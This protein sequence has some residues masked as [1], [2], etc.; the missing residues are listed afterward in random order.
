SAIRPGSTK[1]VAFI[2]L[3]MTPHP[4]LLSARPPAT[5]KAVALPALTHR[6][7]SAAPRSAGDQALLRSKLRRAPLVSCGAQ[8]L[9]YRAQGNIRTLERH[10]RLIYG[11]ARHDH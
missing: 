1:I 3:G 4:Y 8:R 7:P 10:R 5:A 2:S 6:R 11:A 9:R